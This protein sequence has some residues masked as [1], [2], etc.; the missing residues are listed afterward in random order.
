MTNEKR[1]SDETSDHLG[2][3]PGSLKGGVFAAWQAEN[4]AGSPEQFEAYWAML[5]APS[6]S[7]DASE[8]GEAA[9]MKHRFFEEWIALRPQGTRQRFEE[10]W[11]EARAR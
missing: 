1:Q 2:H 4:P 5:T 9:I 6:R 3:D 11:R 7:S 10:E 8:D